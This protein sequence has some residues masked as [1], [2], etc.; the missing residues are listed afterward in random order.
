MREIDTSLA[1]W[2]ASLCESVD[3]GSLFSRNSVV[4][5]WKAPFRSLTLRETVAWRT[6]DLLEQSLLL[7]DSNYLLGARILLR[8]AFETVAILIYLNQLTRKVLSETLN[9]HEFTDKT[10]TLLLGSRDGST[11]YNAVN[12]ITVIEKCDKR[13]PGIKALYASLSESAHPNYEGTCI[14][15]SIV[16][17]KNFTTTFSNQWK[18]MY[19]ENHIQ[20]MAL[21]INVFYGEY[22]EEWPDA[23]EKLEAWIIQNDAQLEATKNGV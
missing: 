8:S 21:C 17:R 15:Y 13:Y 16:D 4:H 11:S 18:S 5:K 19:G 20:F 14:G 2:K 10:S 3:I 1:E 9:F 23:I 22:N 6:Q 12:I 7:Y